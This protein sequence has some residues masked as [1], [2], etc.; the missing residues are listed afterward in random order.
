MQEI[1]EIIVQ[2]IGRVAYE[3]NI[4]LF[5][6]GAVARDEL[7]TNSDDPRSGRRSFDVDF[8]CHLNNWLDYD[9]FLASLEDTGLFQRSPR[10][11]HQIIHKET[12]TP[13]D[14][15]PFGGIESENHVITWPPDGEVEMNVSGFSSAYENA[16]PIKEV[17]VRRIGPEWYAML[18]L[19]TWLDSPNRGKDIEDFYFIARYYLDITGEERIWD[20]GVI[21][22]EGSKE[23]ELAAARL[24]GR[25]CAQLDS[26]FAQELVTHLFCSDAVVAERLTDELDKFASRQGLSSSRFL[27]AFRLGIED[28]IQGQ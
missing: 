6:V 27:N 10:C 15:V 23:Y 4:D 24:L 9:Q 5:L 28:I 20:E 21:N 22:L 13:V 18:K 2:D 16:L 25:D 3:Q 7:F 14:L 1:H 11:K 12:G 26:A 8:A 19:N 17:H